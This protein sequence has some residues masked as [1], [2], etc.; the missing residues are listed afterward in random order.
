[1]AEFGRAFLIVG[2]DSGTN[3]S[4]PRVMYEQL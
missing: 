4:A 1:M 3:C 2:V